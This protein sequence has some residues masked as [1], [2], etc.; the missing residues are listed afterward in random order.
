MDAPIP[1]Y[2][3]GLLRPVPV[4]Q[5]EAAAHDELSSRLEQQ[6]RSIA[7]CFRRKE[8]KDQFTPS[9]WLVLSALAQGTGCSLK[10]LAAQVKITTA[11]TSSIIRRLALMR[12]VEWK[13]TEE[14]RR[15]YVLAITAHGRTIHR[16]TRLHA[17]RDSSAC[18]AALTVEELYEVTTLLERC[19]PV[20]KSAL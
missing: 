5:S 19:L 7:E 15:S 3:A 6:V 20:A 4:E 14:D 1:I 8:P 9:E 2:G 10:A 12:L 13:R 16:R 17:R 11:S 18:F